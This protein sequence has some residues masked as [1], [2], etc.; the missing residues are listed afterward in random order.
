[1]MS[2]SSNEM[3]GMSFLSTESVK[4]LT[5]TATFTQFAFVL[6]RLILIWVKAASVI[7]L[8]DKPI[9]I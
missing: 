8:A 5:D 6:Y 9:N 1:M 2:Y 3:H 4:T 7:L